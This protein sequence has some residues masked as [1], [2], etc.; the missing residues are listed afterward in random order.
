M[1]LRI[2]AVKYCLG[3]MHK[4]MISKASCQVFPDTSISMAFEALGGICCILSLIVC[5]V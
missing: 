2:S 1:W 3:V 4:N 5:G